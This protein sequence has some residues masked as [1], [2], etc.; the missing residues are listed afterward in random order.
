MLRDKNLVP[1]SRQHQHALALCVRIERAI[2][3]NEVDLPAWQ[4]EID[5]AYAQEIQFHFLAEE[6]ELFPVAAQFDELRSLVDTLLAEH[7]LLREFFS[8]PVEHA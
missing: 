8:R 4:A 5:Q 6:K 3:A 1:L 2:F 7:D